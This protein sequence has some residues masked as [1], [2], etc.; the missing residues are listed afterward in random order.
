LD[1]ALIRLDEQ[2]ITTLHMDGNDS[3]EA[4][5]DK[6]AIRLAEALKHNTSL[7]ELDLVDNRVGKNG[8]AKLA[9]AL[10]HN[11][12]LTTLLLRNNELQDSGAIKLAKALRSNTTL[13]LLNLSNNCIRDA[14]ATQ[15]A[16]LLKC[17]RTITE[18]DL[19]NNKITDEGANQLA[20]MLLHNT[21][22]ISL[23][24]QGNRVTD[25]GHAKFKEVMQQNNSLNVLLLT[26]KYSV[27]RKV[28]EYIKRRRSR[29]DSIPKP[30]SST[31]SNRKAP[32]LEVTQIEEQQEPGLRERLTS[33]WD[34]G[35]T[36]VN[37]YPHAKKT[38]RSANV[39]PRN[40]G[41]L[42]EPP[43]F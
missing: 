30:R 28:R 7:T 3:E 38:S 21:T 14:G 37:L 17:N 12:T 11:T 4:L 43:S 22:L 19:G 33:S 20:E 8:A 5:S 9:E 6:G 32:M 10:R 35:R 42:L 23:D 34:G 29:G 40:G 15:L 1:K 25:Q 24:L 41:Q 13:T 18:L 26:A 31:V 16:A 36:E 2:D 27:R 39:S